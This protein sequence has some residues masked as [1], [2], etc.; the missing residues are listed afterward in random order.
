MVCMHKQDAS[1]R[2]TTKQVTSHHG[3]ILRLTR[4]IGFLDHAEFCGVYLE[5]EL[6]GES[7][8]ILPVSKSIHRM[9]SLEPAST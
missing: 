3:E 2:R 4:Q 7:R 1:H 5:K 9:L 8:T 6:R